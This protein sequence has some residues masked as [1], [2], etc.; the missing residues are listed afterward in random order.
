MKHINHMPIINPQEVFPSVEKML[1]RLA[2][3]TANTYPVTF[4][5]ARS[6][7]YYAFMRACQDYK[8]DKGAKFSS[9]CYFW[10]WT[11][12]KTFVTKRTVDPLTFLELD[13]DLTG[14]APPI[15]SECLDLVE[16]L[17]GDAKEIINLLIETPRELI[18]LTMTPKQ[19]MKKVKEYLVQKQGRCPQRVDKAHKELSTCF[20]E[21][22]A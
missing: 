2:W 1:Y 20:Q 3:N 13:D 16:E 10:V 15:K 11:H 18:G 6:E 4:E 7:A 22:W 17:S 21:A 12:L 8:P 9:W 19:F 14:A 5:E